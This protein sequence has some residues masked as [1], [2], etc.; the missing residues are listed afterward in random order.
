MV[1][2]GHRLDLAVAHGDVR[3]DV[4]CDGGPFHLDR[5]SDSARD[6][7]V[8]AEG[9]KVMRFSGRELSRGVERC[10][11]EI[12][13]AAVAAGPNGPPAGVRAAAG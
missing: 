4:E 13:A 3:I 8:E 12:S 1:V 10:V 2:A 7:A 6:A 5:V 11:E 9:W